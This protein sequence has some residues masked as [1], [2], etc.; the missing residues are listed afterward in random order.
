[1]YQLTIPENQVGL[2]T[3]AVS[4]LELQI[5]NFCNTE[6]F[7]ARGLPPSTALEEMYVLTGWNKDVAALLGLKQPPRFSTGNPRPFARMELRMLSG[8]EQWEK[9]ERFEFGV[10]YGTDR[11]REIFERV[12]MEFAS[13]IGQRFTPFYETN[14]HTLIFR[15]NDDGRRE[16]IGEKPLHDG[17][18]V[19]RIT[20]GDLLPLIRDFGDM[21]QLYYRVAE[22]HGAKASFNI[23]VSG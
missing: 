3:L 19:T 9:T 15:V 1:M 20:R 11:E 23:Q 2:I 8:T 22:T 17:G 12:G 4:T 18:Q 5:E 7:I 13:A 16:P 21:V 6:H 14:G 10:D